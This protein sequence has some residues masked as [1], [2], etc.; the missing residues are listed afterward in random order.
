M[1]N[2]I[3][4]MGRLTRDPEMRR[5]A[6]GI[7]VTSFTLAC[8]RDFRPQGEEKQTDFIDVVCWRNTAEFTAKWFHKGQL[9]AVAGRL[10]SRKWTDKDGNNRTS[11]EIVADEAHFAERRTDG[12]SAPYEMP[13]HPAE[14]AQAPASPAPITG[15]SSSFSELDDD[16][17]GDLPF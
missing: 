8:D 5:T 15:S 9:V 6:N 7:P 1:L 2:K 14:H 17:D 4:L 3:V 13:P 10:Q 16:D 11:F 12:P